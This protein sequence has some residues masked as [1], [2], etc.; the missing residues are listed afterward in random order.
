MSSDYCP[1]CRKRT[2]HIKD[3][4]EMLGTRCGKKEKRTGI[5]YTRFSKGGVSKYAL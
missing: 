3:D 4:D 1:R 2:S 5:N